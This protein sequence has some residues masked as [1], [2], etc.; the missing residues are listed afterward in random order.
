MSAWPPLA[1]IPYE[2]MAVLTYVHM[3]EGLHFPA[4]NGTL[5]TTRK[6]APS[7]FWVSVKKNVYIYIHYT[8]ITDCSKTGEFHFEGPDAERAGYAG[9]V[10]LKSVFFCL[11]IPH[12]IRETIHT[13]NCRRQCWILSGTGSICH[14]HNLYETRGLHI[15]GS[16]SIQYEQLNTLQNL[17][18][19]KARSS[20]Y[21]LS[22][23]TFVLTVNRYNIY[24]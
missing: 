1:S 23:G 3:M 9:L 2:S 20:V 24:I 18:H 13:P 22:M 15:I 14:N 16:G 17:R 7:V 11:C 5:Q 19:P 8:Y 12:A 4:S 21:L 10:P 6:V